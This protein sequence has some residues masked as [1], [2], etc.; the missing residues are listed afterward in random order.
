MFWDLLGATSKES[1]SLLILNKRIQIAGN[2]KKKSGIYA[3][4]FI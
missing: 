1:T 3:T 2:K 4:S